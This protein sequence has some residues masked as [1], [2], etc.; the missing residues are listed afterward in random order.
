MLARI[1]VVLAALLLPSALAVEKTRHLPSSTRFSGFPTPD[2]VMH[3]DTS[4]NATILSV[5]IAITDTTTTLELVSLPNGN[6]ALSQISNNAPTANWSAADNS[7]F[8]DI[9]DRFLIYYPDTIAESGV[10]RLRVA[11]WGDIPISSNIVMLSQIAGGSGKQIIIAVDTLGNYFFPIVCLYQNLA[12][13]VFLVKDVSNLAFV[14]DPSLQDTITGGAI[15]EC[16]VLAM[17]S[18]GLVGTGS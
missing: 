12:N 5:P 8:S 4:A 3:I 10:S 17:M 9:N 6:I 7:V 11:A 18:K 16:D 13:K 15:S 2:P 1:V 14:T